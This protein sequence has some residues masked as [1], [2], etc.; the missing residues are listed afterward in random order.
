MKTPVME[1][2]ESPFIQKVWTKNIARRRA[3][4]ETREAESPVNAVS[5]G[6]TE[7]EKEI[8]DPSRKPAP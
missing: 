5:W 4:E 3:A 1:W 6:T 8:E 2:T 7:V